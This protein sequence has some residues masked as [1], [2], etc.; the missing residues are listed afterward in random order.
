MTNKTKWLKLQL[1]DD[2]CMETR[3]IILHTH[4]AI[5]SHLREQGYEAVCYEAANYERNQPNAVIYIK[6]DHDGFF[7]SC[8]KYY[9][10]DFE[11]TR[12]TGDFELPVHYKPTLGAIR[13]SVQIAS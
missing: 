12:I 4:F 1:K 3:Y 2:Q 8:C 6:T 9:S 10:H 7:A 5:Y 11:I 13:R